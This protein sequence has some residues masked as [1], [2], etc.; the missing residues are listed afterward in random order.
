MEDCRR[1]EFYD[2]FNALVTLVLTKK[3]ETYRN[4]LMTIDFDVIL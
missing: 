3:A 1:N 2:I 4:D